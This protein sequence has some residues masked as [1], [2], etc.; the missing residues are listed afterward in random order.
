M[1]WG[2]WVSTGNKVRFK[3]TYVEFMKPSSLSEYR[4][5]HIMSFMSLKEIVAET[6][7]KFNK[8]RLQ[9]CDLAHDK[10]LGIILSA[11]IAIILER[12]YQ[13]ILYDRFV[14]L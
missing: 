14:R 3:A 5:F 12:I 8:D 1:R 11:G 2:I 7:K 4:V 9:V 6:K 10:E 13:L